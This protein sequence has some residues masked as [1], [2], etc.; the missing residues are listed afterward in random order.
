MIAE[1]LIQKI[2]PYNWKTIAWNPEKKS[3]EPHEHTHIQID[4]DTEIVKNMV[5]RQLDFS[6]LDKLSHSKNDT[7]IKI[8]DRGRHFWDVFGF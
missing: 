1:F 4:I 2:N 5:A 6:L 3:E 8:T 7:E